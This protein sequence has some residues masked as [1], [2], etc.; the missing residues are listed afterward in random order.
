[1]R[2]PEDV[3]DTVVHGSWSSSIW[4]SFLATATVSGTFSFYGH[5]IFRRLAATA[6]R[7]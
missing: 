4:Q 7:D 3:G 2:R 5:V 6:A 1:M